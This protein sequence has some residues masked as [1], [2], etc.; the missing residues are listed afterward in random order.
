[1]PAKK[2]VTASVQA[3]ERRQ[4]AMERRAEHLAALT[5]QQSDLKRE[6]AERQARRDRDAKSKAPASSPR[7]AARRSNAR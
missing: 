3:S 5:S 1:M 4:S 2:E 7:K 6:A